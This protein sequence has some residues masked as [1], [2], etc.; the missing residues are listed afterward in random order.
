MGV[1]GQLQA[2]A[3]LPA[4][5]RPGIHCT[6]AWVGP[7]AGLG[8]CRKSR[9]HLDSIP[10]HAARIESL[11]RLSYHSDHCLGSIEFEHHAQSALDLV[12]NLLLIK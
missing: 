9:P 3:A 11:Y 12:H 4:G 10:G 6:G 1:R 8:W 5:K 2:P 7:R